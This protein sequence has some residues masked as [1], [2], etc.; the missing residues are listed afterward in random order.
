MGMLW[1]ADLP[2]P[3]TVFGHGFV[4][5]SDGVKM[6]KS[7]GGGLQSSTLYAATKLI[8]PATL[9]QPR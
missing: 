9:Q 7:I 1:S 6:S 4:T 5:A 2:L 8:S 3:K